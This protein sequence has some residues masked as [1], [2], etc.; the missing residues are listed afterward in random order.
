MRNNKSAAIMEGALICPR[1]ECRFPE[2]GSQ[3]GGPLIHVVRSGRL[4]C[5]PSCGH[6]FGVT[7]AN[8]S[9]SS[10]S[11]VIYVI[12]ASVLTI[13]LCYTLLYLLGFNLPFLFANKG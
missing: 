11:D 1:C 4:F 8:K 6:L 7:E 13:A 2:T 9:S 12:G 3:S 5:C 10:A